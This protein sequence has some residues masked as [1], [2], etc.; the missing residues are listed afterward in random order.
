MHCPMRERHTSWHAPFPFAAFFRH[1][2]DYADIIIQLLLANPVL[3]EH[4]LWSLD[5][6]QEL[7]NEFVNVVRP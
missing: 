4:E 2:P 3:S 7:L 6:S 5:F 1:G